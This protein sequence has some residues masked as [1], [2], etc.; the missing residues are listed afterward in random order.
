MKV[1]TA[2][3]FTGHRTIP[4]DRLPAVKE[5]LE[6]KIEQL[7][8]AGTDTFFSG[9]AIG[10]DMLAGFAVLG[11]KRKYPNVKLVML[12]PCQSQD[13]KWD[14]ADKASYRD[15]LA[16]A[17]E[18]VYVSERD[19]FDGCMRARNIRLV[20]DSDY[21]IAYMTNSGR[22]GTAQ[23]VRLAEK[24]GITVFNLADEL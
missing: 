7:I 15:L 6:S 1:Q 10:F 21:C 9:G 23:T 2:C 5:R 4:K 24:K 20:E 19:Y 8:G 14:E 12:L 18:I 17:D 13:A 16:A 22:S 11:Q 3:C